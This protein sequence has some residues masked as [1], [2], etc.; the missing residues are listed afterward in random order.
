MIFGRLLLLLTVLRES[1]VEGKYSQEVLS[2]CTR[3]FSGFDY[4]VT[5]SVGFT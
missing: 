2:I 4:C 1:Y 3:P 5:I